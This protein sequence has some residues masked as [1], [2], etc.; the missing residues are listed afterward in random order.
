MKWTNTVL[1]LALALAGTSARGQ[2]YNYYG[3][4]L[5]SDSTAPADIGL[6]LNPT[7]ASRAR[8]N[9]ELRERMLR[10]AGA[11]VG[12]RGG[13]ASRAKLIGDALGKRANELDAMYQFSTVMGP[14]GALP[15][16][17]VKASELSSFGTDQIRTADRVYKI[18]KQERFVSVPPTWRDYLFVGLPTQGS[19]ELPQAEA[20][21]K[22]GAELEV[23]RAAVTDGWAKGE[24][25]A[26]AILEANFNR[27]TRDYVGM[28]TYSLLL[29]QGMVSQTRVAES[30]QVVTGD[31]KQL[32]IGDTTRRLTQ[33]AA[34]ETNADNWRP[35]IGYDQVLVPSAP[36]TFSPHTSALAIAVPTAPDAPQ[37]TADVAKPAAGTAD[38][39]PAAAAQPM[40]STRTSPS[41]Q[42]ASVETIPTAIAATP[43]PSVAADVAPVEPVQ[44]P[45]KQWKASAGKTLQEVVTAWATEAG[46]TVRWNTELDYSI[47]APGFEMKGDFL[48]VIR[49]TFDLYADA[50]RSFEL[51][52]R[53]GN[54]VLEVWE[55]GSKK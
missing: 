3:D 37:A 2:T 10:E 49:N 15:P 12:F 34:F 21:P 51:N 38:V 50:K 24:S 53:T 31:S 11:T 13:M 47:E 14:G 27:L 28:F 40:P 17:V 4:P 5:K 35:N 29:Q 7:A 6:L 8:A 43:G 19:V 54:N 20:R 48:D 45:L 30:R 42:P 55:K 16:V 23:W 18:E 44:A 36:G 33:K 26:D 41:I 32:M 46:W 1:M 52:A 9:T 39:Q 25:Q 22:T